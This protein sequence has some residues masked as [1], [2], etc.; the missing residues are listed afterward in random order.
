VHTDPDSF[1]ACYNDK[2][3]EQ[4][5]KPVISNV[6]S[7]EADV[8]C[9]KE[10]SCFQATSQHVNSLRIQQVVLRTTALLLAM[11]TTSEQSSGNMD[12]V[13]RCLQSFQHKN[14]TAWLVIT[15]AMS[16]NLLLMVKT[17]GQHLVR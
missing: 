10:P 14:H 17:V 16:I 15:I 4:P 7:E 9:N 3:W 13:R 1:T 2:S 12:P 8:Q 11:I 5:G 6:R